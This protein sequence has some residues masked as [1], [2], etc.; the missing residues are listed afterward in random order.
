MATTAQVQSL[1]KAHYNHDEVRFKTVAC[2]TQ[3][4]MS[5]PYIARGGDI[6]TF[7]A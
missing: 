1:V 7:L 5:P 2:G 6:S 4:K 3:A